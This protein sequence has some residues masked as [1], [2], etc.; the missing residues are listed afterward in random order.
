MQPTSFR[1]SKNS[2]ML[3]SWLVGMAGGHLQAW[4]STITCS[5]KGTLTHACHA[6]MTHSLH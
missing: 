5:N 4:K 6:T 2:A 1:L 3:V